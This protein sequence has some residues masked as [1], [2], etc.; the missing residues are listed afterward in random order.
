MRTAKIERN[1][2]ETR[3]RLTLSLD[4]TGTAEI[5]TGCGFLDH[6]LTLFAHHGRFDLS[7]HC[8][9]DLHV[10][11][12]HTTED[13]G[14]ALGTAFRE[15]LGDKGGIAR[16]GHF[17]LPMDE[18]LVLCALDFSGRA[19]LRYEI[20]VPAERLGSF[21]TELA[22]EFWQAFVRAAGLTLHLQQLAGKNSHHIL[23]A[24]FKGAARALRTAVT[25]LPEL[26]GE[27][28]STKGLL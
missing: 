16:Y 18:A 25:I 17:L 6:M 23:E 22:E 21:D 24:V 3:I 28:P 14:I 8:T 19:F 9:G 11:A 26:Q 15:A 2:Q 1:T 4:G 20:Q 7:L 12:H 27:I 13:I 5:A 10:D